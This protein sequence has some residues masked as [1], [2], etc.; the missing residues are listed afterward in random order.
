M[1]YPNKTVQYLACF[2]LTGLLSGCL[3]A[4]LS[5]PADLGAADLSS[6]M[7]RDIGNL[8]I[9]LSDAGADADF[10]YDPPWWNPRWKKRVR[11]DLKNT[12]GNLTRFQLEVH[13]SSAAHE[14]LGDEFNPLLVRFFDAAGRELAHEVTG[15]DRADG[16]SFWVATSIP[17]G[18]QEIWMYYD[19]SVLAETSKPAVVWRDHAAV[20]HFEEGP[21]GMDSTGHHDAVCET[22]VSGT[23][24]SGTGYAADGQ[25]AF[26]LADQT[27][28]HVNPGEAL[29]LSLWFRANAGA[30]G[31]LMMAES[32]C[33]GWSLNFTA[34]SKIYA[35]FSPRNP[36][37]T[38]LGAAC[39]D[40]R[41]FALEDAK[42]AQYQNLVFIIDRTVMPEAI[43]LW[44][45]GKLVNT[46]KFQSSKNSDLSVT[47]GIGG[48]S[49]TNS[50][51]LGLIDEVRILPLASKPK[52]IEAHYSN[53]SGTE[54]WVAVDLTSIE[55]F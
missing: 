14:A 54:D 44:I 7:G 34:D 50:Y 16:N 35:S 51:F 13:V 21:L 41:T 19:D 49:G 55:S 17:E 25:V 46:E 2:A 33:V 47:L 1:L 48:D 11:I 39:S 53:L 52:E 20:Y 38:E 29:T 22:C 24:I 45:D 28:S 15:T 9:G 31:A 37:G 27:F 30:S 18:E 8:D 43:S 32:S 12:F 3:D 10:S 26:E 40:G 36:D 4:P 42:V 23:G 5:A 6:D